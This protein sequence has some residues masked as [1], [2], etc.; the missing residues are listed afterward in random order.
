MKP[1]HPKC[2][3]VHLGGGDTCRDCV[4]LYERDAAKPDEQEI[5]VSPPVAR[6]L[7]DQVAAPISG[8][9]SQADVPPKA[10]R[11]EVAKVAIEEGVEK[12]AKSAADRQ[13]RYREKHG[14]AYRAREQERM[15]RR[16]A[17]IRGSP[18]SPEE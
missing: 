18:A 16:R 9:G 7:P 14:D 5:V 3:N 2:P 6:D 1:R 13:R 17:K 10:A 15:K 11:I 12:S 4:R 8:S